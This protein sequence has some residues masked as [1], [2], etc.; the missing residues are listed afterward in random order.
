MAQCDWHPRISQMSDNGPTPALPRDQQNI[1]SKNMA[2]LKQRVFRGEHTDNPSTADARRLKYWRSHWSRGHWIDINGT[3]YRRRGIR[4]CNADAKFPNWKWV[5]KRYKS[6]RTKS[7]NK[8]DHNK[9][10]TGP[11]RHHA[12]DWRGTSTKMRGTNM[13][14]WWY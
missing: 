6:N 11:C 12:M 8:T 9:K 10:E 4:Q 13:E 3:D 1:M 7:G 2:R 5:K 14:R